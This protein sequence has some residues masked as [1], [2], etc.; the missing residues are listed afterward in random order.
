MLSKTLPFKRQN[1]QHVFVHYESVLR[2]KYMLFA[3]YT[4]FIGFIY[5]RNFMLLNVRFRF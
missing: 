3:T 1:C 5:Y 2:T 4:L